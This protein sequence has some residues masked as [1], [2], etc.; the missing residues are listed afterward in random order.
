MT[1]APGWTTRAHV[2]AAAFAWLEASV[3]AGPAAFGQDPIPVIGRPAGDD[4]PPL[5]AAR[6][7]RGAIVTARLDWLEPLRRLVTGMH[8][9]LLF[10]TFGGYELARVT[11]PDGLGVWGPS[12]YLFGD[13][14]TWAVEPDPRVQR[15]SRAELDAVDGQRFWHCFQ[16][17]AHA[18]FG[19]IEDGELVA[20]AGVLERGRGVEEVGMDVMPNARGRGLGRAV[21]GAAGADILSRGRTVLATTAGFNVP[22]ARTLRSVGLVYAF[23]EMRTFGSAFPVPPQA[24]GRPYPGAPLENYYPA[25]AMNPDIAP[26]RG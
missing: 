1:L 16:P 25:W 9:D 19:V 8:P 21:V 26:R 17:E 23:S 11:L 10:S 15:L 22:S 20:L 2:P 12:W 4:D 14:S 3:G 6:C 24:L 5:L 13:A 18:G 7:S